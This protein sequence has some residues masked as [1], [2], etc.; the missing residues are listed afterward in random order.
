MQ[1]TL[2]E[3]RAGQP[4]SMIVQRGVAARLWAARP[5]CGLIVH[6]SGGTELS[7]RPMLKNRVC[8]VEEAIRLGADAVSM[9]VPLGLGADGDGAALHELG[10]VA[11]ACANWNLPLLAMMYVY[12]EATR[13]SGADAHAARVAAD[14]GADLV[15]VAYPGNPEALAG[16]LASC[17]VPV[18][19]AGGEASGDGRQ[20]LE[21]AAEAVTLG[22]AGVCVGRNV[23]QHRDP[24]GMVRALRAVVHDGRTPA[25]AW[26]ELAPAAVE[27]AV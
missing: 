9:H 2:L 27:A 10:R 18:L 5:P 25:D 26:G 16:L 13:R 3:V 11:S 21:L 12:G 7:G 1:R 8:D 23:Y 20:T 19:V 22:A 15:K 14:L 24:A 6:L 17:Y 4:D